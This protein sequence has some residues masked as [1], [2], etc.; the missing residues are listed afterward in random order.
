MSNV[1]HR[2]S[3]IEG[4]GRAPSVRAQIANDRLQVLHFDIRYSTFS[5]FLC[6]TTRLVP[7]FVVGEQTTT[8]KTEENVL[9][10]GSRSAIC[11]RTRESASKR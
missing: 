7:T 9:W 8:N 5:S 2:M 6:V 10:P 1:E 4:L 3:N 11:R